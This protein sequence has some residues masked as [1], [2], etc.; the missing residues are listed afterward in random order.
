MKTIIASLLL[1]GAACSALGANRGDLDYR[2]RKLTWKLEDLQAKPDKRIP[3][4]LLR[5]AQGVILLDRTKAGFIFAY[6]GG[7]G[8]AMVRDP[9]SR[10]WSAPVFVKANEASLGFQVGGQQ[11]FI[12]ILL[13]N[14]NA[15]QLLMQ[16]NFRFGGE[17]G[18]TAGNASGGVEGSIASTEPLVVVYTDREGL[19]GGAALKGGTL[20]PDTEAD[21]TYYNRYL[22]AQE[23]LFE[24]KAQPTAIANELIQ[25]M[26]QFSR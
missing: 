18:G 4:E 6:E 17:A 10:Q 26:E 22:S 14:T 8:V 19:F 15:A 24:H 21:I 11:S 20:A 5:Q 25:K 1:V 7:S 23:I 9:Q 2:V 3:Q 12:V 16:P 13:M